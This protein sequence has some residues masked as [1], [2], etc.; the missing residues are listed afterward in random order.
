MFSVSNKRPKGGNRALVFVFELTSRNAIYRPTRA[1]F[2][3]N[4]MLLPPARLPVLVNS[5]KKI[6]KLTN[7]LEKPVFAPYEM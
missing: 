5:A 3:S 2:R 7:T 1:L 4:T 6:E